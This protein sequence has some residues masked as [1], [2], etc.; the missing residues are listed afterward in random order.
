ME[1][2][3]QTIV[4]I[5]TLTGLI[6]FILWIFWPRKGILAR[7]A[8]IKIN[9]ERI[10]LEDALKFLYDCEY[11]KVP[12]GKKDIA[13]NLNITERACNKLLGR[14]TQMGLISDREGTHQLTEAGKSYS[15]RIIRVHRIWETYLANETGVGQTEWH[16]RADHWEHFISEKEANLLAADMGNPAF[17]P[18]GDPIPT[19]QGDLP[20]FQGRPLNALQKGDH[21]IITHLEDEPEYIY[22]QLVAI[23]L[24]PGMK[25]YILDVEKEKISFAADGEECVLTPL[26]ASSVTVRTLS[27][28][29]HPSTQNFRKL[30]D[31]NLGETARIAGISPNCRGQERRRLMDLGIVRGTPVTALLKSASGD[32]IG[33]RIMDTT[34]GIRKSQ[35]ENIY[36]QK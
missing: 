17:D 24:Y 6:L 32:P 21:A 30:T 11:K 10:L 36:I 2:T 22:K 8:V 18:H 31:L 28:E 19:A 23:G 26:F 27:E 16:P 1:T 5:S 7:R 4:V 12:C 34:I 3:F 15:L 14:L 20:D 13:R 35:A 9:N 33:Y 29:P 25:I